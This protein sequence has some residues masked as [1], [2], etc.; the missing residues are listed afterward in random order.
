MKTTGIT[1]AVCGLLSGWAGFGC[2]ADGEPSSPPGADAGTAGDTSLEAGDASD[3]GST[4]DAGTGSDAGSGTDATSGPPETVKITGQVLRLDAFLA[5]GARTAVPGS[6]VSVLGVQG[7]TPT[8]SDGRGDYSLVVPANGALV[9]RVDNEPSYLVTQEQITVGEADLR[10]RDF[11]MA[12]RPQVDRWAETFEVDFASTFTCHAPHEG[13]NCRY[14]MVMGAVTESDG[15]TPVAGVGYDDFSL[16]VDGSATWYKKGPYFFYFNGNAYKS[17]NET[18]S[19][20]DPEHGGQYRGGLF[21]YYVEIPADGPESIPISISATSYANGSTKRSFG[22]VITQALKGGFTW[23]ALTERGGEIPPPPVPPVPPTPNEPND[24]IDP[25][26]FATQIYPLF[27]SIPQGG[28]GCQGCHTDEGGRSPAGGLALT[29]GAAAAFSNLDPAQHPARVSVATPDASLLLKKPLYEPSGVQD[30][31]IFAFTSQYDP[32]YLLIRGWIAGGAPGPRVDDTG[33]PEPPETPVSFV[34]DVRPLLSA[35]PPTGIGCYGCH[36]NGVDANTAP[37]RFFMGGSPADLYRQLTATAPTDNGATGE[38]YRVN[39]LVPE[40]S[41]LL[42]NPLSGSP[43]PHPRK[44]F[45]ASDDLRYQ[46]LYRWIAEGAQSDA[47]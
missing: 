20:Q 7:I 1:W 16:Q 42:L 38:P 47:P 11:F 25:V 14:A 40:R 44:F 33:A 27:F 28:Y 17:A 21:A 15:S 22:P 12:Y 8:R 30:H 23:L 32:P 24:P 10:G 37:G 41:L 2:G 45:S 5:A 29:G 39:R 31:P 46:T 6:G 35:S 18:Q 19:V 9:L 34:N 13:Q 36:V 4:P 43:E 26:D 3:G